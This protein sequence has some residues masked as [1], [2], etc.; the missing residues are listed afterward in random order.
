MKVIESRAESVQ[1]GPGARLL[2][3]HCVMLLL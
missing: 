2:A 1:T 3:G